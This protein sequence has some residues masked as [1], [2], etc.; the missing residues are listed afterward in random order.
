MAVIQNPSIITSGLQAYLD[1]LNSKSYSGSGNTAYD[2]S[3]T[4][5]TFLLNNNPAYSS[6]GYTTC[7]VFDGSDDY[8]ECATFLNRNEYTKIAIFQINNTSTANVFVGG[9]ATYQHVLWMAGGNKLSAG[10][11]NRSGGRF[12]RVQ[13]TTTLTTSRWYFGAV[14]FSNSSGFKLYLNQN[15]EAT[16]ADTYMFALGNA[17]I[18]LAAH[19][20]GA[21]LL[22]G[23]LAQV[24]IYNRALSQSEVLQNYYAFKYRY[25]I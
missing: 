20:D 8:S 5:S 23:K 10:H 25:G 9:D 21:N 15:L 24:L 7:L 19:T 2:L 22:N 6:T 17:T 18:H 4:G 11:N 16:N 12:T 3:G 13:S 14:S 1:P